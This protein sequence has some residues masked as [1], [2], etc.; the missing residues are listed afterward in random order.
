VATPTRQKLGAGSAL[1][2]WGCEL[3]DRENKTIW[4][5]SSPPGYPLYRKFGFEDV[6]TLDVKLAE[7]SG[8]ARSEGDNWGQACAVAL[9]GELPE[10]SYRS[11]LMKRL[12]KTA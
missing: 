3:A 7:L 8:S 2:K 5:E 1:L 9:A 4:L 6:D 12:P 10:G 11:V